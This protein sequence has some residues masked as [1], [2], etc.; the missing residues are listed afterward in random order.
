MRLVQLRKGEERRVAIVE[1]PQLRLL[2]GLSSVYALA[3]T[4]VRD[5][6]KLTDLVRKAAGATLLSYDEVYSGK[7]EWKLMVPIDHPEESARC[8]ISGT[9]LTHLGSAKNRQSM[10]EI[11]EAELTDSMKM[12]Q[13][14]IERGRPAANA[15]GIAPEWFHK[16]T[17][18]ALRAHNEPLEIPAHAED[19][20]EEAEIGGIYIVGPDGEPRRIGFAGGNEFSDHQFE[21]KN[22]LNLAGSKLRQCSLGPELV[23]DTAFESVNV[24]VA[25]VRDG[26]TLWSKSFLSGER[27]MC[28]SLQNL[29][30]HHFKF[31]AHRRPGDVHV[32]FFGTAALSF[33]DGIQLKE[34]D[35]MQA[36]FE[37]FGRPLLNPV[38]TIG[39]AQKLVRAIPLG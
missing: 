8:L 9:G 13:W 20:G 37:G 17:G 24:D 23:I 16:G 10:H 14:G 38:R 12:F 30:H 5:G 7:S 15:I 19:G 35:V 25:I 18:T 36:S 27:G 33:S 2:D 26:K 21:K 32:H 6:A 29:E 39:G 1:E 11:T 34:G 31:E 28:H 22:Y 3:E 4:V